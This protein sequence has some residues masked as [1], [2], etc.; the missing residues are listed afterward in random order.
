[1]HAL[2]RNH[3]FLVGFF[4]NSKRRVILDT[5]TEKYY[6]IGSLFSINLQGTGK[7]FLG[8]TFPDFLKKQK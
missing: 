7:P 6:N 8:R 5:T 1:M 4:Y 3:E 2:N